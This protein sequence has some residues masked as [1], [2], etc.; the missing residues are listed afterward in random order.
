MFFCMMGAITLSYSDTVQRP[1]ESE[2]VLHQRLETKSL[3]LLRRLVEPLACPYE[4]KQLLPVLLQRLQ[5]Q[6]VHLLRAP[7]H[8][9][10]AHGAR[11]G[12]RG[13]AK[14]IGSP[15]HAS[16]YTVPLMTLLARCTSSANLG[17][18]PCRSKG[19]E[20][21][22]R[23]MLPSARGEPPAPPDLQG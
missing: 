20:S 12:L 18:K 8:P 7:V 6:P 1:L 5:P 11:G 21:V 10:C 22:A 13:Q 9:G 2:S 16:E 15:W 17:L 19:R 23:G 3:Q 14:S 4:V